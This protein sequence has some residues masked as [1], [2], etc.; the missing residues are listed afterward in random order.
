MILLEEDE[1]KASTEQIL[2]KRLEKKFLVTFG[3]HFSNLLFELVIDTL[4]RE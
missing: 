4:P 2:D 3:L 1:N